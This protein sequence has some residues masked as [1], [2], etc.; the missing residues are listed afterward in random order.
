MP[1][2][3]AAALR[4]RPA[5]TDAPGGTLYRSIVLHLV[6]PSISGRPASSD[7]GNA[8]SSSN[9]S[10]MARPVNTGVER[11]PRWPANQTAPGL[12]EANIACM[13]AAAGELHAMV[14]SDVASPTAVI[15]VPAPGLPTTS[16]GADSPAVPATA[17]A[18]AAGPLDLQAL[19]HGL[20]CQLPPCDIC[21]LISLQADGSGGVV[22][23]NELSK[24]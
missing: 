7:G 22:F 8:G 21:T 12:A 3:V 6:D 15:R 11:A 20:L 17:T 13:A 23:Q 16:S 19:S 1:L 10:S 5:L 24:E 4:L 2:L 14:S 9:G 18:T